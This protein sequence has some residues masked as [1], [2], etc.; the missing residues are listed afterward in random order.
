MIDA[1]SAEA[2]RKTRVECAGICL[3]KHF[4]SDAG[5]DILALNAPPAPSYPFG[6]DASGKQ[7]ECWKLNN[8]HWFRI[9]GEGTRPCQVLDRDA[10]HCM[11]C[12]APRNGI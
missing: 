7:C 8:P 9:K 2:V 12:G 3:T 11:D 4:A 10:T 6:K 5:R 1:A